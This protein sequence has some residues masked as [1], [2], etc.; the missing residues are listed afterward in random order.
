MIRTVLSAAALSL[1]ACSLAWAVP[2]TS[3]N[4]QL[5]ASTT[6]LLKIDDRDRDHGKRHWRDQAYDNDRRGDRDH[7]RGQAYDNDW[8][9]HYSHRYSYCPH[10][11]DDRRCI[12]VSPVWYCS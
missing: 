6:D 1:M 10:D 2:N 11:W 9:R 12:N 4:P 5:G 3:P 7:W 8:R